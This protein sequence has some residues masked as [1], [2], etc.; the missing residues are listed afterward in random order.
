MVD[1]E[2]LD[3]LIEAELGNEDEYES[4]EYLFSE[5]IDKL[6]DARNRADRLQRVG[7]SLFTPHGRE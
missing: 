5:A 1:E 2:S 4:M 7:V 3:A 6:E